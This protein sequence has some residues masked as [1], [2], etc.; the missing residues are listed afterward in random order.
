MRYDS[1]GYPSASTSSRL[2]RLSAVAVVG[3]A[4][5]GRAAEQ[6]TRGKQWISSRKHSTHKRTLKKHTRTH[7][8]T[9]TPKHTHNKTHTHTEKKHQAERTRVVLGSVRTE[10][11]CLNNGRGAEQL[12]GLPVLLGSRYPAQTQEELDGLGVLVNEEIDGNEQ[13]LEQ[14]LEK[15]A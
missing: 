8:N 13:V 11:G 9:C 4:D 10:R 3:V 2:E 14:A 15:Q 7:Q 12:Q 6:V 1:K 5:R